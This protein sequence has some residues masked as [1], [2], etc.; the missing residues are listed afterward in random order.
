MQ[1]KFLCSPFLVG[2]AGLVHSVSQSGL[3]FAVKTPESN[4][5]HPNR[6]EEHPNGKFFEFWSSRQMFP[7]L[8][9]RVAAHPG[10]L[11]CAL[12]SGRD[13]R[14]TWIGVMGIIPVR[15]PQGKLPPTN[16]W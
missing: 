11:T 15:L 13:F 8:H 5:G 16:P 6:L 7:N 9:R 4:Y 10:I 3:R 12:K 1:Y 2:A 14:L